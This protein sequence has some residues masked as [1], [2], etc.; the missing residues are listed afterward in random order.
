MALITLHRITLHR[1]DLGVP[2]V[3]ITAA[4]FERCADL[5][6]REFDAAAEID[7]ENVSYTSDRWVIAIVGGENVDAAKSII[8]SAIEGSL[9]QWT[10]DA[11]R[12]AAVEF[13][14]ARRGRSGRTWWGEGFAGISDGVM[15]DVGWLVQQDK[16]DKAGEIL[17][18]ASAALDEDVS[19]TD[20]RELAETTFGLAQRPDGT[21]GNERFN[22]LPVDAVVLAGRLIRRGD[23]EEALGILIDNDEEDDEMTDD[24]AIAFAV[25]ALDAEHDEDTDTYYLLRQ[26]E[27]VFCGISA[28]AMADAGREIRTAG[29]AGNWEDTFRV[30]SDFDD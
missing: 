10:D 13:Y 1:T 7:Y 4:E 16:K 9:G 6:E 29:N 26:G 11:C 14:K 5:I 2:S 28:A 3:G 18:A 19:D 25:D 22:A 30:L 8:D 17:D 27:L 24:E 12:D 21:W 23:E 20:L 15:A